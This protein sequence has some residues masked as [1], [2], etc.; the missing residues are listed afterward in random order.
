MHVPTV[1]YCA[2]NFKCLHWEGISST[3]KGFCI[4]DLN[5]I[6]LKS[7]VNFWVDSHASILFPWGEHHVR[8]TSPTLNTSQQNKTRTADTQR[9]QKVRLQLTKANPVLQTELQQTK[10]RLIIPSLYDSNST[11]QRE[12]SKSDPIQLYF[13]TS[14]MRNIADF[15]T[16]DQSG[17]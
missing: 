14:C 17:K 10:V 15:S 5:H 12:C 11:H 13:P 9:D 6:R 3:S 8:V 7:C 2:V 1:F 16:A 4:Q